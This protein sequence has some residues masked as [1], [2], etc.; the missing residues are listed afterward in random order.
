MDGESL[1]FRRLEEWQKS[2]QMTLRIYKLTKTYPTEER[3]GLT[4]QTRRAAVSVT[5]NIVEGARRRSKRD[6]RHFYTISPGSA[7]E[8]LYFLIL[9]KDL[10]DLKDIEEETQ[11]L[12]RII[13][14]LSG[15]TRSMEK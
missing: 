1:H 5:A 6:K 9:S 12:E 10:G 2:H 14:M 8:L 13:R 11:A 3:F 4:S 15:L 7:D